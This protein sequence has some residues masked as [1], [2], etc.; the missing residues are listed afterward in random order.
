M[1]RERQHKR[2]HLAVKI[3]KDQTRTRLRR[4]R[5]V[6][7]VVLA[8]G[9]IL[10][11]VKAGERMCAAWNAQFAVED[12]LSQVTIRSTPH[13]SDEMVRQAFGLT[14]GCNLATIDFAACRRRTL[15]RQPLIRSIVIDRRGKT[16]EIAVE[17]RKPV[18]RI[19][20]ETRR[21]A[22]GGK[23]SEIHL[24]DA[25]DSEG[26]VFSFN[27]RDTVFMPAIKG[28]PAAVRR[29]DRIS[30]RAL[31]ALRMIEVCAANR[32]LAVIGLD[33]VS[34]A[35]STYMQ[36]C[37]KDYSIVKIDWQLLDDPSD[38]H[39]ERLRRVLANLRDTIEKRLT[40]PRC[41]YTISGLDRVCVLPYEKDPIP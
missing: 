10:L 9:A 1:K 18:A 34:V 24:W 25:V 16:L 32:D 2:F 7:A 35:N 20:L 22:R 12:V 40:P 33:S 28:L 39:Q 41:T 38:P 27:R 19:N 37:T 21:I 3:G 30:G 5:F 36:A 13:I 8:V 31:S 6:L 15:E 14:N 29:G 26:V 4:L 23:V 11:A 17:E